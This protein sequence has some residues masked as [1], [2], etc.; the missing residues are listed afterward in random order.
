MTFSHMVLSPTIYHG[1]QDIGLR[2]QDI[3]GNV[4]II[5]S[6]GTKYLSLGEDIDPEQYVICEYWAESTLPIEEA[7]SAIAAEQST[8][9]WTDVSTFTDDIFK[10]YGGKVIELVPETAHKGS[11]KIAFPNDDMSLRS[12]VSLRS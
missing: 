1:T 8:G 9:T 10:S 2:T 4:V 6:Y 12:A 3:N 7:A 5:M 11:M